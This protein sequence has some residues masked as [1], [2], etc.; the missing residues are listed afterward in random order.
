MDRRCWDGGKRRGRW[1]IR[2]PGGEVREGAYVAGKKQGQW[3]I[4]LPDGGVQEGPYVAGEKQ[5]RWVLRHADGTVEEGAVVGGVREGRWEAH[6]PDGSRRT[7][8]MAGGRLVEGSVRVVARA[9][10]GTRGAGAMTREERRRVQSALAAQ[11]FD[12]GPA[13]GVFGP[14]TRR[15]IQAWQA[16]NGYA[17]TGALTG[18]QAVGLHSPQAAPR[19]A[20]AT[21]QG[22]SAELLR[23]LG[24][25]WA[26]V[27]EARIRELLR[28]GADPN[29]TD[30]NG[31]TAVH[32][33]AAH[34]L[35]Y[36]RA[37]LAHGGRCGTKNRYGVTPLHVA[38]AA[39][40]VLGGPGPETVRVLLECAPGTLA[41]R[42]HRGNTPLHAVYAGVNTRAAGPSDL[43][44]LTE[45]DGSKDADVLKTLLDAE[46]DPNARNR[47]GDTPMLL[48]LKEKGV[49]FTHRSQLRLLL[50]AGADP[51]TRDGQ[52]TPAVTQAVLSQ[53]RADLPDEGRGAG[54][55]VAECR[56]GPRPA[57]PAGGHAPGARGEVRGGHPHGAR[58]AARRGGGSVSGRP[59]REA[60][61]RA[62]AGGLE[63][64]MGVA[65]GRRSA[66]GRAVHLRDVRGCSIPRGCASARRR[67]R[68][69]KRTGRRRRSGARRSASARRARRRPPPGVR[70]RRPSVNARPG[71]R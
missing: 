8:E 25:G 43:W 19:R 53:S 13:D 70:R 11:G 22:G 39:R 16:S 32:Y 6:R 1:V 36:L 9:Q 52:G 37:V 33:A 62:C 28:Q 41:E 57:G 55:R 65:G 4:R 67:R 54:R 51:D 12:P 15:A 71:R 14:R 42:D 68:S 47:A 10:G 24:A 46:A 60:A 23:L 29:A 56:G 61:P 45:D 7:F 38:A 48:L 34:R 20:Q 64:A 17:A 26:S 30:G 66:P 63:A 3:V 50:N 18:A 49:V 40:Q 69:A 35:V 21:A 31:H 27:H 2:L 44:S 59:A 5:G 58:G